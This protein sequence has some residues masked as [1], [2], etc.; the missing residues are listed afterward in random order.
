[1]CVPYN[2]S[3][4]WYFCVPALLEYL[5]V[6]FFFVTRTTLDFS[7]GDHFYR[8]ASCFDEFF[9]FLSWQKNLISR[10]RKF[11]IL[12]NG[13]HEN[14]PKKEPFPSKKCHFIHIPY[15]KNPRSFH[16]CLSVW[17][18]RIKVWSRTIKKVWTL[19]CH[20]VTS[21]ILRILIDLLQNQVSLWFLICHDL[22]IFTK[23]LFDISFVWN[24]FTDS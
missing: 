13:T 12:W 3:P 15:W 22:I 6:L 19:L 14:H 20:I 11:H 5:D 21:M 16:L 17:T 1:M 8:C 2:T 7:R 23:N 24:I 10:G 9:K 4:W 18:M